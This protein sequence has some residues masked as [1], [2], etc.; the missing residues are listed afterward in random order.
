M[1]SPFASTRFR[2]TWRPYQAR[3]LGELASHL[4]DGRVHLVAPPGSG[5][6][7]LGLETVVRLGRPALVLA[8]TLALRDQWLQR[9]A[10]LFESDVARSPDLKAP[11]T[12]TVTT[13]HALHTA[14]RADYDALLA[15]LR[16]GEIGTLVVD[17]AHHLRQA[18]WR[19]LR[20]LR[21][22]LGDPTTV[23]LTATPPYDVPAAEWDRYESFCGPPDADIPIP[24]LVK[25]GHLCPHLDLV[26][27]VLPAPDE[28]ARL[29]AFRDETR[30]LIADVLRDGDWLDALQQHAWIRQPEAHLDAIA[31]EGPEWFVAAL[32]VLREAADLDLTP[33]AAAIGLAT[34]EVPALR[35]SLLDLFLTGALGDHADAFEAA[36]GTDAPIRDLRRQ[37]DRLGALD[38][39]RVRLQHPASVRS[40]LAASASKLDGAVACIEAEA[41]GRSE[42]LRAVVLADRIRDAAWDPE[43]GSTVLR[44]LGVVPL[45][46]RLR[47]SGLDQPIGVLTGRVV[48]VPASAVDA[49]RDACADAGIDELAVEALRVTPEFV[50]VSGGEASFVGPMTALFE[51]G[52]V[53]VLVGTVAL[54]GEGWDAPS[55]NVLVSASAAATFVRTGQLRGRVFRTDPRQPDKVSSVWHLA[56][57][58]LSEADGGPNVER[59]RRRF[60][61]FAVPRPGD[62]PGAPPVLET[63]L[64]E[65]PTTAPSIREHNAEADRRAGDLD[66]TR[67]LWREAMGERASGQ[68]LRPATRIRSRALPV[69]VRVPRV[70]WHRPSLP[71]ASLVASGVASGASGVAIGLATVAG[72]SLGLAGLALVV[73]GGAAAVR[74]STQR[75]RRADT[76]GPDGLAADAAAHAVLDA[77]RQLA[78]VVDA[79]ATV[80]TTRARTGLE[81]RLDSRLADDAEGFASSLRD[82]FGP[83]RSPRYLL[84]LAEGVYVAVPDALGT[85]KAK[86]EAF[87]AAWRGRL[88]PAALVFTRTPPGR[89]ELATARARAMGDARAVERIRRW[90]VTR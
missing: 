81:I 88:G 67:A 62:T 59:L 1:S 36:F 72:A 32:A 12:L 63:G 69:G 75:A 43:R 71:V 24:E 21:S 14:A 84:R 38:G 35:T 60:R 44:Q 16:A 52:V 53:R 22:D 23:A 86:A 45:F 56:S 46:E 26:R 10:D 37:L 33:H 82:L 54:L 73:W 85:H 30:A 31:D 6:T 9:F 50:R 29:D 15:A 49:L 42:T 90:E 18:W 47:A 77:L 78:I 87:A 39:S 80:E 51:A 28:Q 64:P 57:V 41:R 11:A 2:G 74:A 76:L 19:T 65:P 79:E 34:D 8:P 83:V 40:A 66:A 68:A 70:R 25:A 48:V 3:V 61:A 55:A 20:A 89:R 27:Y 13:Y 5:K 4:A 17:E 58:D 7:L